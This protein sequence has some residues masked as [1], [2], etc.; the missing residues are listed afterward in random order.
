MIRASCNSAYKSTWLICN[1]KYVRTE[2]GCAYLILPAPV[3]HLYSVFPISHLKADATP[4][5]TDVEPNLLDVIFDVIH[6]FLEPDNRK[7]EIKW[8]NKSQFK[9]S[10][11]HLQCPAL[12]TF[13]AVQSLPLVPHSH[14][15]A[16]LTRFW[17]HSE[18]T[19]LGNQRKPLHAYIVHMYHQ[20][21]FTSSAKIC[22]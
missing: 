20:T 6:P 7:K 22:A 12:A 8:G 21:C 9:L 1:K 11:L 13:Q 3:L 10:A 5:R 16:P 14:S 4:M 19:A 17:L 18:S 15:P 2:S